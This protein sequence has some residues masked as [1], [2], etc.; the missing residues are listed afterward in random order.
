MTEPVEIAQTSEEVAP[1][2]WHWRIHNRAI[3]GSLSSSQLVAANGDVVLVDPVRL[4]LETLA[5]LPRPTATCLT[6]KCHQRA[7]W[8]YRDEL[9]APVWAPEGTAP[10]DEEPDHR[11]GA[12]DTLPAG[13]RAV[14]TPGPEDVH[15]CFLL[16]REGGGVLLCS[17]LLRRP[18]GGEL[19]FVP[20]QYHDDPDAT[21][22]SVE[23]LLELPFT[24]LCLDH[25]PPVADDPKAAIRALLG[26]TG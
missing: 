1:G 2:V 4:A 11:Y 14:H 22:R 17:D 12:G 16:E 13:L 25:G 9:G 23:G 20:L 7:A 26:R 5:E 6:A 8:R 18:E 21:R 24:V 15:F 10:M 19:D 3:G